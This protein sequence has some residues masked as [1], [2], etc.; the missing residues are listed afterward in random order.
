MRVLLDCAVGGPD[1]HHLEDDEQVLATIRAASTINDHLGPLVW[2]CEDSIRH[3]I[4]AGKVLAR[5]DRAVLAA[6]IGPLL[7]TG[8]RG[9]MR[10]SKVEYGK[11]GAGR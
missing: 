10:L 4:E 5:L 7:V 11:T 3:Q 9:A 8:R 1:G 2:A 6:D